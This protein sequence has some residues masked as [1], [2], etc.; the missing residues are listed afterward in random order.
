MKLS[1]SWRYLFLISLVLI[2]CERFPKDVVLQGPTMGTRYHVRFVRPV[3]A[4]TIDVLKQGIESTLRAINDQMSTYQSDSELSRFNRHTSTEWF[5]VSYNTLHVI[6]RSIEISE[7]SK[8]AFDP[9]VGPLVNLWGFGN[10]GEGSRIPSEESIKQVRSRVGFEKLE[11]RTGAIR[12]KHPQVYVDLSAIAKGFAVDQVAEYLESQGVQTL[13]VEIGGE[14]RTKGR[15]SNGEP[16][17]VGV[18]NPDARDRTLQKI[19]P[20]VDLSVATSGDYRN[21]IEKE[22]KRYSHII[23]PATA[24]PTRHNLASVT[25]IHRKCL[26]ADALATALMVMGV[27]KGYQ[28]A[29]QENLA[30]LFIFREDNRFVEKMTP[31]FLKFFKEGTL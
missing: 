9:T 4:P 28:M 5:P 1:F 17:K 26:V 29:V 25:V 27:E 13:M 12:K 23:D 30:V 24:K 21:Y 10:G 14:V 8:G 7:L 20:L 11:F 2:G 15:K 16:W 31:V 18:D 6:Q 22:G 3:S 19:I